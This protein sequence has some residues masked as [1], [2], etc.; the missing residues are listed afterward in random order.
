MLNT[1]CF[2]LVISTYFSGILLNE[3]LTTIRANY[4]SFHHLPK[5][6]KFLSRKSLQQWK[7]AN[8]MLKIF[9]DDPTHTKISCKLKWQNQLQ[10][11]I[12][13]NLITHTPMEYDEIDRYSIKHLK[14]EIIL[15]NNI[16]TWSFIPEKWKLKFT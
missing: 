10:I 9:T 6:P 5:W 2:S 16:F 4:C 14:N 15:G 7:S 8:S 1:F 11:R 12:W 13:R 3:M